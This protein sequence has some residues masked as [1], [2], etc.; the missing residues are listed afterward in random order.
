MQRAE[1]ERI[2]AQRAAEAAE[3][4]EEAQ[5]EM[6]RISMTKDIATYRIFGEGF[7]RATVREKA[8]FTLEALDAE[9]KRV[10]R[11]GDPIFVNIQ[12]VTRAR[13]RIKDNE[14]GSYTV[15]WRPVQSGPY[16][17]VVANLGKPLPGSPFMCIASTP[18]P[19]AGECEV[20][21]DALERC[22]ARETQN[23]AVSFRDRL[24]VITHAVDLDVFVEPLPMTSARN[25][26]VGNGGSTPPAS[27]DRSLRRYLPSPSQEDAISP[28]KVRF[29]SDPGSL[30]GRRP[31]GTQQPPPRRGS[32]APPIEEEPPK[33]C[34]ES[35]DEE[36]GGDA[37]GPVTRQR[38][39]R[40][41]V[42]AKP[43]IVRES[44]EV[45]S[46]ELGQLMPGVVVTVIEERIT[47]G[48]VRGLVAL[49]HAY[50]ETDDGVRTE[51]GETF[52]SN[53][54]TQRSI[55]E[56]QGS[57]PDN[58][59][60]ERKPSLNASVSLNAADQ[61]A[62]EDFDMLEDRRRLRMQRDADRI[63]R[64]GRGGNSSSS[65][66][67]VTKSS[68]SSSVG[69]GNGISISSGSGSSLV[70]TA[71]AAA[72]QRAAASAQRRSRAIARSQDVIARS[73]AARTQTFLRTQGAT[74]KGKAGGLAAGSTGN[75]AA[76]AAVGN[77]VIA[78]SVSTASVIA[79]SV[80]S[81]SIPP[82]AKGNS[83][84][85]NAS[86]IATAL[87]GMSGSSNANMIASGADSSGNKSSFQVSLEPVVVARSSTMSS[88]SLNPARATETGAA[89]RGNV[90][91]VKALR[92]ISRRCSAPAL[93]SMD[94]QPL[95]AISLTSAPSA[96]VEKRKPSRRGSVA[97]MEGFASRVDE[98]EEIED[99]NEAE[100]QIVQGWVT[101][102]KNGVKLVSSRLRLDTK[103]RRQYNE[104]WSRR[105]VYDK[106][107]SVQ[108]A[109]EVTKGENKQ[110]DKNHASAMAEQ[111]SR[112]LA[113]ELQSAKRASD[114]AA[115]AFGGVY[116]GVLH[117]HGKLPDQHRV[118]YSVGVAGQYLLHVRLRKQAASLKGSPF[119]LTVSPGKAYALSTILPKHIN[120]E[121]GGLCST[122]VSTGDKMGNPCIEGG[123]AIECPSVEEAPKLGIP[124]IV[125]KCVD[126]SDGTYELTW[127]SE[128]VGEYEVSVKIDGLH[129]RNSPSKI[130]LTS[131][132][133]DITKC[134]AEGDGLVQVVKSEEG[135]FRLSFFDRF[136]NPTIQ[137]PAFKSKF[138]SELGM[139][140]A[141]PGSLPS[142]TLPRSK[143]SYEGKWIERPESP[144]Q[145]EFEITYV[146]STAGQYSLYLWTE[147]PIEGA[148]RQPV[149]ESP[150][151]LSVHANA[152]DRVV[153]KE[154]VDSSGV[155]PGDYKVA[156]P[157]F[158]AAMK[159]WGDCVID[160]FASASTA[161]L[162]RFW[163]L[164]SVAG[165][166]G[167][168]AFKQN[169]KQN[170]RIWAH[171]PPEAF[172]EFSH[173]ISSPERLSE[174]IV[175]V[176]L[177]PSTDWYRRIHAASDD[178]V[179]YM[180]GKLTR[181]AKDAP[182]RCSEWP[183]VIFRIPAQAP[184]F[185]ASPLKLP[186]GD[187]LVSSLGADGLPRILSPKE[188][189]QEDVPSGAEEEEQQ[190]ELS[191]ED[192]EQTIE[193]YAEEDGA[194]PEKELQVHPDKPA[195]DG[196][197]EEETSASFGGWF[198]SGINLL[199]KAS[200][201][202][203]DGDGHVGDP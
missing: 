43:L 34:S 127:Y 4:D 27:P 124:Q 31:S 44:A 25:S 13:A 201:I 29:P 170:L 89:V 88:I 78:T 128:K 110:A 121:V 100:Q 199:E 72:A 20:K 8:A 147:E 55:R 138:D 64:V 198:S 195:V 56:A 116:P 200:G 113:V 73:A 23:F 45:E 19:F 17:I 68:T 48:L 3:L 5:A 144:E 115:F 163:T 41:K 126:R 91:D 152:K 186:T 54:A 179:K 145:S 174:L 101:L 134:K 180:A 38:H 143:H 77:S 15:T 196:T 111:L 175:C 184:R 30:R 49:D 80:S 60:A 123:G 178:V 81:P 92:V 108:M 182:Q 188:A 62:N 176:P 94:G 82:A 136:G 161:L 122:I 51:S 164:N 112:S 133:P 146:P 59:D 135:T 183:I 37:S 103:T 197:Q 70:H 155:V 79:T 168:N 84:N 153:S 67:I 149:G 165:S 104:Q 52:R 169:W 69:M 109:T 21:G 157:V 76:V 28:A 16:K 11:G 86:V 61:A 58:K 166:D 83:N 159:K 53:T 141:A 32:L 130:C 14:D 12:G 191:V 42:G 96:P 36:E 156:R 50:K 131:T 40:V 75:S 74:R 140:I 132:M 57:E 139:G 142:G 6:R 173:F 120:G 107:V 71:T 18:E 33:Q 129:V 9:G 66:A 2:E 194:E 39:I 22:M 85:N 90:K 95:T 99:K 114:Q 150:W 177:R 47:L 46:A 118:F 106:V 158:D 63:T 160:S 65:T 187:E 93:L 137:T 119:L 193:I 1:V 154:I 125:A 102:M 189:T 171:P 105:L 190:K 202:D 10:Y 24:G 203:I 167:T 97:V 192:M 172:D 181:V 185:T 26:R 151:T 7:R 162:P 148:E 35:S 117:S 98:S 87:S